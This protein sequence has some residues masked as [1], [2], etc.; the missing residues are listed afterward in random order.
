MTF[1]R[2]KSDYFPLA[3]GSRWTYDVAGNTAIDSV[4][5]DSSVDGRPCVVVLRDYAPEYWTK[6]ITEVR[7]FTSLVANRG[8]QD[9]VL[10][11]RYRLVYALPLI[12]GATWSESY[13]DTVVLT[14]TDTVLLRTASRAGSRQSTTSPPRPARSS[15][16]TGLRPTV[17]SKQPNSRSLKTTRSGLHR[18]SGWSSV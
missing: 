13:R 16:A 8:G 5:G 14:G 4:V 10:E 6:Q 9:Y 1:Y 17:K 12:E 3:P 15:S 7:Q 18:V 11:E 2:A